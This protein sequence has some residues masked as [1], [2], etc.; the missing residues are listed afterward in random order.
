M[1]KYMM[2]RILV[3]IF[4]IVAVCYAGCSIG[5]NGSWDVQVFSGQHCTGHKEEFWG[6]IGETGCYTIGQDCGNVQSFTVKSYLRGVNF[7]TDGSCGNNG[8]SLVGDCFN[9][10]WIDQTVGSTNICSFLVG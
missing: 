1:V 4:A 9:C 3:F 8:G 6:Q 7:Y 5:S 2:F 10:N